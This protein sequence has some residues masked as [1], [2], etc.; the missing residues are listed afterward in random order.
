MLRRLVS[1]SMAAV[2]GVVSVSARNAHAQ[3]ATSRAAPSDPTAQAIA[4][5]EAHDYERALRLFQDAYVAHR[6]PALLFNIAATLER[7]DRLGEAVDALQTY[8]ARAHNPEGERLAEERLSALRARIAASS[9]PPAATSSVSPTSRSPSST[10]RA[11][12]APRNLVPGIVVGGIGVAAVAAGAVV[13][14]LASDPGLDA[15]VRTEQQYREAAH[16]SDVQRVA[17][18]VMG[19]VGIAAI[20]VGVVLLAT[21]HSGSPAERRST[22]YVAPNEQGLSIG[23]VHAF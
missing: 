1:V 21:L 6:D 19:G 23:V 4:A 9:A 18:A 8:L 10:S 3:A 17:G 20:A 12:P 14:A 22:M 16:Q 15:M 13:F 11:T 2:L 7:L 5:F